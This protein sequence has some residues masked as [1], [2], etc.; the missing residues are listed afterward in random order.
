VIGAAQAGSSRRTAGT[1]HPDRP[2]PA[3]GCESLIQAAEDRNHPVDGHDGQ[4]P[5]DARTGDDEPDL[6]AF[7]LGAP[8]GTEQRVSPAESQNRV[9]VMSTT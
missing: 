3:R 1:G 4:D 6:A 2:D 5:A 7:S 9:R 8:M